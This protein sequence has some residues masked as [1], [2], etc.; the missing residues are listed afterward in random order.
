MGL[1]TEKAVHKRVVPFFLQQ[2]HCKEL[3]LGL[4]HLA[5]VGVEV[6]DVEPVIAPVMSQIGFALCN[7][8]GVVRESV[9]YSSAVD[10]EVFAQM[11]HAYAG[12]LD[13][14]AGISHAPGAFPFKL[15]IIKFGFGEPQNEVRFV[16]LVGIFFHAL[17]DAHG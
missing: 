14:P 7:L 8:I 9:V 4:A 12:A 10:I 11:L 16:P 15:L 2:R 3:P 5:V 1:Q 13:M 17:A 6:V